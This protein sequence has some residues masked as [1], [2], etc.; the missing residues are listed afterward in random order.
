MSYESGLALKESNLSLDDALI[1]WRPKLRFQMQQGRY[2]IKTADTLE[3]FEATIRLRSD[4][5]LRE[6]AGQA[7]CLDLDIEYRDHNADFLII[8]DS[9]ND[10]IYATYRLICSRFTQDF[11]SSS[12]FNLRAFLKTP[13]HKLELSRACVRADKRSSGIFLHLLWKGLVH[14]IERAGVRYLFGCSSIQ[15]LRLPELV[16]VYKVLRETG[17]FSE[18]HDIKPHAEYRIVDI[19]GILRFCTK[20]SGTIDLPPLLAAYIKAGAKVYGAP[21]FDQEFSCLDLFTILDF[22]HPPTPFLNRYLESDRASWAMAQGREE[23]ESF[24]RI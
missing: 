9:T 5:F 3:E 23:C 6:F 13:G 14:Y 8:K 20:R 12:E 21:A 1:H 2:I 19:D 11:Y 24:S 17:A 10:E 18:E 16:D 7:D 15:Y 4:I 22:E